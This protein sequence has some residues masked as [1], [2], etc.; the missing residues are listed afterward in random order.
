[1]ANTIENITIPAGTPV[2]LYTAPAV[3]AAGIVAGDKISVQNLGA[4]PLKLFSGASSPTGVS[5][6][7]QCA[8][9]D[10]WANQDGDTGAWVTATQ[11][12]QVNVAKA[13]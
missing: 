7:R 8:P 4:V 10:V 1:M 13:G 5:G 12:V 2:N 3:L 11:D 6:Y 9:G